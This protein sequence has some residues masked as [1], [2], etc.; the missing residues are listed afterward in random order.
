MDISNLLSTN[1]FN[2]RNAAKAIVTKWEK[3]GLLEGLRTETEKSGMAQLLENQA[4]QLVK[5]ATSTGT[6]QGSEEWNGVAL[7]LVRRIFAEFAAKEFVSV[8]PMNLP[9][10]LIFYLD[11]KYGTAQ[12]G[13]DNDNN[14]RTGDPFGATNAADS[15][16][17]VTTTA[18]DPSGG[19]YGAGRFGYSVNNT[20]SVVTLTTASVTAADV[21][22]DSNYY[23]TGSYVKVT[24]TAP[25]TADLY[26]SRTFTLTTGSTEYTP[27]QA[28]TKIDSSYGV[29][30]IV[31][32]SAFGSGK[33]FGASGSGTSAVLNFSVHPGDYT[34]GDL[35]DANPCKGTA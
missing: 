7:P 27:V 30:M 24:L 21:N 34:R 25:S 8:Q 15:M 3:T 2:Q 14:N 9:S 32:G 19:L 6:T 10:G 1:D 17:G 5:E 11:F 4:R 20:A 16:F 29:T 28:F 22:Y 12:P 13:F 31:T 33:L 35:E 26:A 23:A 18:N